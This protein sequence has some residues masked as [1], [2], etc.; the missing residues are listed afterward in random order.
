[1]AEKISITVDN[2][3]HV[4]FKGYISHRVNLDVKV[5]SDNYYYVGFINMNI[6]KSQ[7]FKTVEKSDIP[8]FI[9]SKTSFFGLDKKAIYDASATKIPA[10]NGKVSTG[11]FSD[12]SIL[13]IGYFEIKEVE[14]FSNN[15]KYK[16]FISADEVLRKYSKFSKV[17]YVFV[18]DN[19]DVYFHDKVDE[20]T[21]NTLMKMYEKRVMNKYFIPFYKSL[22]YNI[23]NKKGNIIFNASSNVS[24]N[25][26]RINLIVLNFKNDLKVFRERYV[27]AGNLRIPHIFEKI[28]DKQG[29]ELK[30]SLVRVKRNITKIV[31]YSNK[32]NIS[33]IINLN[34]NFINFDFKKEPVVIIVYLGAMLLSIFVFNNQEIKRVDNTKNEIMFSRLYQHFK[35]R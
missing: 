17:M 33:D 9:F 35:E 34:D 12:T 22:E 32:G 29:E 31:R 1:M 4:N 7:M 11:W 10:K 6:Y 2:V 3:E 20:K 19:N 16:Q 28:H 30:I 13:I 21:K 26:E 27:R 14:D 24:F 25:N 23:I 5:E 8:G 18:D 15:E